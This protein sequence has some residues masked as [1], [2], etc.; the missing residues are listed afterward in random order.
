MDNEHEIVNDW[1]LTGICYRK[2]IV[3]TN[4]KPTL[5]VRLLESYDCVLLFELRFMKEYLRDVILKNTNE[6][7]RV[8]YGELLRWIGLWLIIATVIGPPQDS[9]FPNKAVDAC[10]DAPFRIVHYMNT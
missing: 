6:N 10:S 3:S 5:K 4:A 2:Q 9:F 8:T 7:T 1:G